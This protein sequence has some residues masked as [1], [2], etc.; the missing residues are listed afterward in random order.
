MNKQPKDI[1]KLSNSCQYDSHLILWEDAIVRDQ[2]LKWTLQRFTSPLSFLGKV[3]S[4]Y[5]PTSV[6]AAKQISPEH[7]LPVWTLSHYR[8]APRIQEYMRKF[9]QQL[10]FI[11]PTTATRFHLQLPQQFPSNPKSNRAGTIF[12][13]G[14]LLNIE[15]S[16]Q[17]SRSR[18][19]PIDPGTRL[20]MTSD[21]DL[22][23]R[24]GDMRLT[25]IQCEAES[26]FLSTNE[27][28]MLGWMRSPIRDLFLDKVN[29]S[30]LM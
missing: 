15:G 11:V 8:E 14:Q 16:P 23:R 1:K 25:F 20:E 22:Y 10:H 19:L 29:L 12:P 26:Y 7:I 5:F 17:K 21:G 28:N 24:I 3:L 2:I 30:P 18:S 13:Y 6:V 4:V 27:S 9:F